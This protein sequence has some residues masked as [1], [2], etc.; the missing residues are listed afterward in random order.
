M[1]SL[2]CA[3]CVR[4]DVIISCLCTGQENLTLSRKRSEGNSPSANPAMFVATAYDKASEAWT[5]SS[6][7]AAVSSFQ[8]WI[9]FFMAYDWPFFLKKKKISSR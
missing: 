5:R 1:V 4:I 3:G 2:D 7:T 6:P 8:N 9:L